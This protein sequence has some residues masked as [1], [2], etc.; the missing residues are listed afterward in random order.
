MKRRRLALPR[1][2]IRRLTPPTLAAVRAGLVCTDSCDT[3]WSL[4][5]TCLNTCTA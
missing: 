5:F 1:E 4:V 2:V 3:C